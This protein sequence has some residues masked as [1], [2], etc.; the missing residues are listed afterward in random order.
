MRRDVVVLIA[1]FVLAACAGTPATPEQRRLAERRLLEPFLQPLQVGCNELVVELTGNFHAN[2]GQPGVDPTVHTVRKER[3]QGFVETI[4]T[5]R[6]GDP[7]TAFVVTIGE[8]AM[9]TERGLER[10]EQTRF[11]VVGEVRMRIFE[12]RRPL[13]LAARASGPVVIVQEARAKPSEVREFS[14]ADGVLSKR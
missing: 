6:L 4:W 8:P 12:D 3:G 5:N 11:T 14:I 13:T 2:V 9:F 10:T 1:L 7:R